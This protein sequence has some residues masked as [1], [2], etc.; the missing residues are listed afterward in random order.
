MERVSVALGGSGALV[1]SASLGAWASHVLVGVSGAAGSWCSAET[2]PPAWWRRLAVPAG[3]PG[4]SSGNH[5]VPCGEHE[6]DKQHA[7]GGYPS[8]GLPEHETSCGVLIP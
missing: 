3:T 8:Q 1:G 7:K 4:G 5:H 6:R 2:R